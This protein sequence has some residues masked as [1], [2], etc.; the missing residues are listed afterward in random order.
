MK[1][2][3]KLVI[4]L[5]VLLALAVIFILVTQIQKY[6]KEKSLEIY[7]LGMQTGYEEVTKQLI[8]QLATCQPVPVYADNITLNAIAVECL[9]QP[10]AE[11]P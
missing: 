7:Q 11:Q 1:N 4:I 10:P 3:K 2:Q 5:A 9:Q 8:S 6:N